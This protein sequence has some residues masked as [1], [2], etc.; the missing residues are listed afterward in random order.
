MLLADKLL[1]YASG[2]SDLRVRRGWA[3]L[4]T[5]APDRRPVIGWDPEIQGLFHVAG[6]GGFGVTTSVVIGDIASSLICGRVVDWVDVS[7]FSVG[8]E[9]LRSM[10]RR[11][12]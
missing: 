4:R 6:L 5:F 9:A 10:P 7:S 8:R 3:C 2:L 11:E 12:D 1:E